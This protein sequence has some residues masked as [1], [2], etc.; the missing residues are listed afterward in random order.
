M[1]RGR[2]GYESGRE[3]E[4]GIM[5]HCGEERFELAGRAIR[6]GNHEN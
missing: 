3:T 6:V 4:S 2:E 1:I 5:G